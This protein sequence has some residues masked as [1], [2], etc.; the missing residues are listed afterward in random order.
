LLILWK[1]NP[2]TEGFGSGCET[3]PKVWSTDATT[4]TGWARAGVNP[5]E[6]GLKANAWITNDLAPFKLVSYAVPAASVSA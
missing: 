2:G 1:E 4:G 5:V 6:R 3:Y